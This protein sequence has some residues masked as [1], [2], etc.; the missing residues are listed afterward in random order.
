[1]SAQFTNILDKSVNGTTQF[2]LMSLD[3]IMETALS[4]YLAVAI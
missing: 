4:P 3:K 1:M 2:D